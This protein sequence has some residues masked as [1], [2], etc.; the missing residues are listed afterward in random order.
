LITASGC[1]SSVG[2]QVDAKAKERAMTAKQF[3]T[4]LFEAW[5]Q[6][7]SA[8][9]FAALADDVQWTA[10]GDTPISGHFTSRAQYEEQV[11]RRLFAVIKGPINCQVRR[12]VAEGDVV[13]VQWHGEGRTR[14]GGRY[15]QDY[16]WV[17][18]VESS[19]IKSVEG[20]FDTAAVQRLFEDVSKG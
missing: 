14:S 3:V 12:I 5:Q 7:D 9:F 10:I 2:R 17:I 8:P 15:V 19:R 6:G 20:Y 13:V 18:E 11:Y 1:D 16:C 4:S